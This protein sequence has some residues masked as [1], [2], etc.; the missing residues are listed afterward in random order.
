MNSN[1][2]KQVLEILRAHELVLRK[3][4]AIQKL[5]A[6]SDRLSALLHDKS[7]EVHFAVLNL[8]RLVSTSIINRASTA[9]SKQTSKTLSKFLSW[10]QQLQLPE[11]LIAQKDGYEPKPL[12]LQLASDKESGSASNGPRVVNVPVEWLKESG[13]FNKGELTDALVEKVMTTYNVSADQRIDIRDKLKLWCA[14]ASDSSRKLL[15][16]SQYRTAYAL[17]R[18]SSHVVGQHL[19]AV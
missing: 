12:R 5:Y 16:S 14:T 17:I 13:A 19:S 1:R 11:P 3:S 8:L 6:S 10:Y 9:E 18:S 2:S 7:I 15:V 4:T